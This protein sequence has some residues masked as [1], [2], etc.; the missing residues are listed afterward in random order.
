[1]ILK[2]PKLTY[3]S[4]NLMIFLVVLI[5]LKNNIDGSNAYSDITE[6]EHYELS[7]GSLD[8][9]KLLPGEDRQRFYIK[10]DPRVIISQNLTY[11][12][13]DLMIIQDR[14]CG[15]EGSLE[16]RKRLRWVFKENENKLNRFIFENVSETAPYYFHIILYSLLTSVSLLIIGRVVPINLPQYLV[17]LC[18]ILYVF[19]FQL[20]EISYSILEMLFISFALY[21]SYKKNA[22]LLVFTVIIALHSRESGILLSF[23]WLLFN[24]SLV[25]IIIAIILSI[26]IWLGISNLDII[27]CVFSNNFLVSANPQKGQ[28][29]YWSLYRGDVSIVSFI[30]L[31]VEAFVIPAFVAINLYFYCNLKNKNEI[32]SIIFIYLIIFFIAT[33][34]LHHSTK[35]LLIPFLVLLSSKNL[36]NNH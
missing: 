17:F 32:L 4:I 16:N 21:A 18:G 31:I 9:Q 30:R 15:I 1:M 5:A 6:S 12:D 2:F 25:P 35:L 11:Q 24:R 13:D 29:G 27:K 8:K 36:L 28:I 20:S 3:I 26:G 10:A 23:F 22:F 19:Q 33:P 7:Y 34:L 14:S